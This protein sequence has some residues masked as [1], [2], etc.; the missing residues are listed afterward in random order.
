MGRR[1]RGEGTQGRQPS[2]IG[3]APGFT[4]L[5]IIESAQRSAWGYYYSRE[6]SGML[7]EEDLR[8]H[9]SQ[10]QGQLVYFLR[11]GIVIPILLGLT[12]S[13]VN[14]G[15]SIIPCSWP[16]RVQAAD[17]GLDKLNKT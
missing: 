1:I 5:E 11:L 16:L 15:A 14:N 10:S 13:C 3:L 9:T 4:H 2:A 6:V 12:P 7:F 17:L 8:T